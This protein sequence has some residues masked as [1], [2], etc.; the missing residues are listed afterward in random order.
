MSNDITLAGVRIKQQQT[1]SISLPHSLFGPVVSEILSHSIIISLDTNRQTQTTT[2][3]DSTERQAVIEEIINREYEY[4]VV[5]EG[6]SHEN[7]SH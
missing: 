2:R 7:S 3:S 6:T 1:P 5:W 4:Q